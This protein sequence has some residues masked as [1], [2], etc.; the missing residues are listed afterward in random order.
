M[1]ATFASTSAVRQIFVGRPMPD[2]SQ[3]LVPRIVRPRTCRRLDGVTKIS[4]SS[5]SEAKAARTKVARV[6]RCPHCRAYH[7]ATKHRSVGKLQRAACVSEKRA[8]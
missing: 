7:L 6:Y 1:L 2:G 8:A 5:R 4:Y 3:T